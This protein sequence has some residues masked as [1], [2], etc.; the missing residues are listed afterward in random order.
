ML[1]GNL[2]KHYQ[3]YS[4]NIISGTM[5]KKI[6]NP[7]SEKKIVKIVPVKLYPKKD[8]PEGIASKKATNIELK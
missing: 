3:L 6:T 7:D 5:L 2:Q 1:P 8:P 4:F